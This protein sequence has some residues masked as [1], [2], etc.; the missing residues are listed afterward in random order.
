MPKA[1]NSNVTGGAKLLPIDDCYISIP[2]FKSIVMNNLPDI[3][4]SKGANYSDENV[5]GRSSPYKVYGYS[6]ART[7]SVGIHLYAIEEKDHMENMRKLRAIASCVYP[8]DG[9]NSGP[10]KPPP[11]CKI[12]CGKLLADSEL[13]VILLNYNVKYPIDVA[14]DAKTY[15]PFRFDI[16]TQWEVVYSTMDLPGSKRILG[17]GR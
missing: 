17:T 10:Y 12:K 7:I 2:G 14:W 1:T 9:E 4:D 11:V 16:E 6:N 3:S 8:R 15:M 5:A 13:C